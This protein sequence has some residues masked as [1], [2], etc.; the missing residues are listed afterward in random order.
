MAEAKLQPP[1]RFAPRP[2][3]ARSAEDEALPLLGARDGCWNEITAVGRQIYDM[4]NIVGS[5]ASIDSS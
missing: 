5:I 2:I 4:I 3:H 1:R